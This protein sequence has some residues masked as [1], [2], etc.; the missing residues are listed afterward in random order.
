[1]A[2]AG[3]NTDDK[4]YSVSSKPARSNRTLTLNVPSMP[5]IRKPSFDLFRGGVGLLAAFILVALLSGF[6]GGWLASHHNDNG[7]VTSGVGNQKKIVSSQ[8]QLISQIAKTVG[9]SVVSV[10]VSIT[11]PTSSDPSSSFFG[12]SQPQ[13]EQA[14]G[15]GIII[16]KSGII[17]TNRHVVPEGTTGVTVTL[18]D[19]TEL[20]DVTVIGRTGSNDNLDVAFLK[21]GDTKGHSLSPAVIGDSSKV[22]VGDDAVAIGNALGQFQNTVTSGIISGY[23]RSVVASDSSGSSAS[24]ENLDNLFQ[25]D[26]AINAGN[27]GGPLVN[28]NGQVIGINTATAGNAQ[29][30][31]F[32]IPI[33]DV[34][35]LIDQVIKNGKFERPYLGVRYIPLTADIAKEYGLDTDNGA[36]IA[37][38]VDP[39]NPSVLPDSPAAKAGLKEKD[40]ITAIDGTKIDQTHSL[41]S[42]L[43]QHQPGD[44]ISLTVLRGNKTIHLDATLEAIPAATQ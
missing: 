23:G 11:D 31:G 9:P 12:F 20:R 27:S 10:N 44:K 40:I 41:T 17:M 38:A 13:S 34:R 33:N 4:E 43:S 1:M 29:N 36:F 2:R 30:I 5:N 22:Q 8:S 32:A 21:V 35:G 37:P 25:T 16:S 24:A 18:S 15:T 39:A 26:A 14:A 7:L 6:G 3:K 19:G 42:Q 28:L